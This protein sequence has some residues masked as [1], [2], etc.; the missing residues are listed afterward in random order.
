MPKNNFLTS[1]L[2]HLRNWHLSF[3]SRIFAS[4][5]FLGFRLGLIFVTAPASSKKLPA[6][7]SGQNTASIKQ[8]LI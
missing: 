6:L 8:E 3:V 1:S 2:A 7:K 4:L 5:V